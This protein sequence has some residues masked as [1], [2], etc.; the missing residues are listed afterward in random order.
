MH[1]APPLPPAATLRWSVVRPV[2]EQLAPRRVLEIGCGQGA[3]G[4]RISALTSYTGVE[5]DDRSFAIAEQ[6]I[7]PTG[8]HVVHGGLDKVDPEARFDVVC[9]FEVLEH[10]EDDLGAL[11]SWAARL[12]PGGTIILSVPAWPDRFGSWD[13]Q[14]GHYRR[15]RPEALDGLLK[16]VGCNSVRH[17]LYGWPLG[18]ATE[19]VRNW[20]VKRR[21]VTSAGS[22]ADRTAES[23]R[24]L[25]PQGAASGLALRI[26]TAPFI[27]LQRLRP[28]AGVGMVG[29]GR[30]DA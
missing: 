30:R 12:D 28:A 13:A 3:F 11:S 22:M 14:V 9:A 6:R 18:F 10:I 21:D 5:P 4:A 25:Q 15:Y 26:G 23:G 27:A 17:T 8:G 29:I 19:A 1:L 24:S 7:A 2:L 16:D 20:I